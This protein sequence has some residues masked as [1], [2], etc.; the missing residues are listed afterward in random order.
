M[1]KACPKAGIKSE[2]Y[3]MTKLFGNTKMKRTIM[4][5]ALAV[6]AVLMLIL[7]G[8][9][10]SCSSGAGKPESGAAESASSGESEAVGDFKTVDLEGN[11]VT[12][13]IFADAE[14]TMINFW[15]T[16]C[17]PCVKEM[18][19]LQKIHAGYEG[20]AQ[21]IG[22][23]TDVNFDDP[24]SAEYKNAVKTLE[25]AEAE[26]KNV[27]PMGGLAAVMQSMQFVPTSIFVD[28]EGK[29]IGEPV[30]GADTEKYKARIEEY[31]SSNED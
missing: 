21:I 7:S 25:W 13:E 8:T 23:P 15:A 20:R 27:K 31:L 1:R 4:M 10:S 3:K 29:I 5:A 16:F 11:E 2:G 14:I 24:E 6:A 19:E 26:F 12:Q 9:L 18:P 30:I 17:G 22:V 28:S